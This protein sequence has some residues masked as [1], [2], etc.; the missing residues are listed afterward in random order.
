MTFLPLLSLEPGP[1]T[2]DP[3]QKNLHNPS[4]PPSRS[5][6]C[7]VCVHEGHLSTSHFVSRQVSS[8][9]KSKTLKTPKFITLSF[10]T[11]KAQKFSHFL[12]SFSLLAVNSPSTSLK[13]FHLPLNTSSQGSIFEPK[14]Q[15][16]SL[17]ALQKFLLVTK[18]G[19][20]WE[21]FWDQNSAPI[22]LR[23]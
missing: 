7:L 9:G 3:G 6:A 5:L 1:N 19:F 17:L 4:F 15:I 20:Y 23:V 11:C 22:S 18:G 10:S 21:L 8:L 16:L 14:L 12:S 2:L 13:I